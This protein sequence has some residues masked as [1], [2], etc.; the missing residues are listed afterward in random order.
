MK[1][2][3]NRITNRAGTARQSRKELGLPYKTHHIQQESMQPSSQPIMSSK[4]LRIVIVGAGLSGLSAA[5]GL[6]RAGHVVT[7]LE[8]SPELREVRLRQLNKP[9]ISRTG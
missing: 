9:R 4:S 3:F 2:Y 6:C 7:V 8:Q 5:I 1:Q